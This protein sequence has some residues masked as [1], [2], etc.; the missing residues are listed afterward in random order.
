MDDRCMER[1]RAAVVAAWRT[2]LIGV[3]WV[4]LAWFV[5]LGITSSRPEWV[6]RLWG[7]QDV[8]WT[9]VQNVSLW[10]FGIWKLVLFVFALVAIWLTLWYRKLRRMGST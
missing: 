6:L 10:F 8:T 2:I 7:G 3:I 9:T 5:Y 1:L 4:T